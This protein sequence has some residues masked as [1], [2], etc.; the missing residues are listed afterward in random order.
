MRR[1]LS[2]L[3]LKGLYALLFTH[4]G[5]VTLFIFIVAVLAMTLSWLLFFRSVETKALNEEPLIL[6]NLVTLQAIRDFRE[7]RSAPL[8]I[9]PPIEYPDPFGGVG[10]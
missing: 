2:K 7:A 3:S 1:L 9:T 5:E 4:R 8:E 6:P 10:E